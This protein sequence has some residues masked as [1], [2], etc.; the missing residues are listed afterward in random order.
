MGFFR[1][2]VRDVRGVTAVFFG[3]TLPV[4]VGFL[5][6]GSETSLWFYK[7]REMQK[8][9]D[10]A[11]YNGAVELSDS[12]NATS[13]EATARKDAEFHGFDPA[14]GV[15]TVN[16]PP[17]SGAYQ[18]NH[19][20]EVIIDASYAR[21][22]SAIY[23]SDP[24]TFTVRAV[25]SFQSD[26][27]ACILALHPSAHRAI[28]VGGSANVNLQGCS[29]MSNSVA[30]DS[31]YQGG[32]GDM[33]APCV[34]AVGGISES[35]GLALTQCTEPW[36]YS[37]AADDPYADLPAPPIPS[38]CSTVPSGSGTVDVP[39]G[40]YCGGLNLSG[41][42]NLTG[43]IYV[44]DGGEFRINAGADVTGS[45]VTFY[46][47]NNASVRWNGAAYVNLTAPTSGTYS[48][49]LVFADRD[50]SDTSDLVFNGTADS[51]LVGA[52]YAPGR[53]V[54]MLGDFQGSNG[55]TQLIASTIVL[56]GNNSFSTDCTGTGLGNIATAGRTRLVE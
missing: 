34:R 42:Y 51:A 24:I 43:G 3:L 13:A 7:Q 50:T 44:I 14:N 23:S 52:I 33:S 18:D 16:T 54:T 56:N 53:E 27:P 37:P 17:T 31:Y 11:A 48:G 30:E 20:V 12:D 38:T 46:L 40:R 15:L 19:S 39:A 45:D 49:V 47:T 5:A 25:A 22:F 8:I 26:A 2:F 9:V 21:L 29:V 41:D 32:S 28:E 35:G 4:T 36:P 55:C 1:N 10:I 6:L